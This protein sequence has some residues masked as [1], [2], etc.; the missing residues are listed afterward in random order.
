M[1]IIKYIFSSC[2]KSNPKCLEKLTTTYKSEQ[3]IY[4]HQKVNNQ[5][6]DNIKI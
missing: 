6:G 2:A 3:V 5:E 1:K 4:N